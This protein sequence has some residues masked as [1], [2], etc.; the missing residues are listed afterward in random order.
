MTI[1]LFFLLILV[2]LFLFVK[3]IVPPDLVAMGT[4]VL[5]TLVGWISPK[6]AFASFSN[7]APITVAAMFILSSGLQRCGA[8]ED[9]GRLFRRVPNMSE[10]KLLIILMLSVIACSAFVN[11]TPVVVALLPL[12]LGVAR[13]YKVSASK[14]LIPLSFAAILGGTCTVIGTSTNIVV[15]SL[16]ETQYG[17]HFG[18]FD[19]TKLGVIVALAG[20]AYMA[21]IGRHLLPDRESLASL[22]GSISTRE[23]VTEMLVGETS[24]LRGKPLDQTELHKI[25]N[26]RVQ[27]IVRGGEFLPPPFHSAV[28]EAG[29]RLVLGAPRTAME[30]VQSLA[31][32]SLIDEKE[33]GLERVRAEHTVIV[34]AVITNNSHFASRTLGESRLREN[35]SAQVLAIHRHGENITQNVGQVPLKFGDTLLLRISQEGLARLGGNPDILLLSDTAVA[36]L[37]RDKRPIV[38]AVLLTVVTLA[39]F[40]VYPISILALAGVVVLVA[41]RCL[42][43]SEVYDAIDWRIVAMIVGMISLG[44]AMTNVGADKW[45]VDEVISIVG[46]ANPILVL[47]AFY[48]IGTLLTEMISNNAVAILLTP[49]AYQ[50][51][52]KLH[53][54]PVPFLIAIM[55]AAS[56][57][58]AT[59]IG[60]QTN[61]FVYGAGGYKF[62]DFLRVGAPLNLFFLVIVTLLIPIFWPL[63]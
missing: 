26:V 49:I 51:A 21:L 14:L 61:T 59:P 5:V 58:F 53:Y 44:T 46:T 63:K 11:N 34:E 23:Y 54:D 36:S 10:L 12:V 7:E 17:I 47:G 8:I 33:F 50:T 56:A 15:T 60:Y 55:F 25:A 57:S 28:L 39:S 16:A 48:L 45:L 20:V 19:I 2:V 62:R 13:H 29:D 35:F 3:E 32:V 1:V 43:M 22:V 24:P 27:G 30:E 4:L 40:N 38:L 42:R 31:G 37:R 18:I 41:T 6:E 9:V 52:V